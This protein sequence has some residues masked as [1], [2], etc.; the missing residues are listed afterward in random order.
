MKLQNRVALVT[1]ASK[2]IGAEI[3]REAAREG[4]DVVINYNSDRAGAEEVLTA[5]ERLGRRGLVVQADVSQAAAVEAMVEQGS[6]AFGVIDVLVNNAGIALWRPFLELSEEEWDCTLDFEPQER[7]PLFA[8]R[9]PP[10]GGR[11]AAGEYHQHLIHRRARRTR[12]PGALLRLQGR[13]E[14]W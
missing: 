3:A 7:V 6:A 13:D 8:G 10:L 2:G 9:R 11:K 12:L 4:A 5:V 1:G 14:L